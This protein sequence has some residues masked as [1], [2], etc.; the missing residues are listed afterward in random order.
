VKTFVS[1]VFGALILSATALAE[2]AVSAAVAAPVQA[3]TDPIT[4]AWWIAPISSI[5][6]IVFAYYFYKKMMTAPAGNAK[7]IE[8]AQAVREGAFAYLRRQY[9][10]VGFIF[11][12]L[13]AFRIR[14]CRSRF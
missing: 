12:L 6:A 11:M 13:V 3:G 2:N 7:M 1:T 5:L 10:V 14:L 8:I 4:L 9:T